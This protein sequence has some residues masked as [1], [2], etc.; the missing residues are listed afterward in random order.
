MKWIHGHR[1]FC[2]TLVL[3]IWTSLGSLHFLGHDDSQEAP[4][5]ICLH[6]DLKVVQNNANDALLP[7]LPTEDKLAL[8]PQNSI[9]Q[10][11]AATFYSRRGPPQF[12]QF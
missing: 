4:C 12:I 10:N 11:I 1:L 8:S 9:S 2:A 5:K 6:L 7:L 3:V